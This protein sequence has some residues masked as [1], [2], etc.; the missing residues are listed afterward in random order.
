M[1]RCPKCDV[2]IACRTETCPLCGEKL[3]LTPEQRRTL[4][5]AFPPRGRA[6]LFSN[7]SFDRLY[8]LVSLVVILVS[9]VTEGVVTHRVPWSLAIL[10]FII[11]FYFLIRSTL[12]DTT[13]FSQKVVVQAVLLSVVAVCIRGVL[14]NPHLIFEWILPIIYLVAMALNGIYIMLHFHSSR[15]FLLNLIT[16]ALMCFIP[17]CALKIAGGSFLTPS[18]VAAVFGGV[19]I[20]LTLAFSYRKVLA[21]L[22]RIF[23]L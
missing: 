22:K 10:G 20:F 7:A 5:R 16:V 8:W 13:Y 9:F 17:I 23:H 1:I 18:I 14:P 3:N 2:V 15:K 6:P 12:Q 21:E 11:Y 19:V 4:P